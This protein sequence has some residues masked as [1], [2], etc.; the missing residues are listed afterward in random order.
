M[1][2]LLLYIK[3]EQHDVSVLDDV[4]F[5]FQADQAFFFGCV[6]ASAGDQVVVGDYLRPDKSPLEVS[7]DLTAAW[8]ALVPLVMVHARTSGSPAVR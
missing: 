4:I 3:P 7:V 8:G 5:A 1:T 6:M 2:E